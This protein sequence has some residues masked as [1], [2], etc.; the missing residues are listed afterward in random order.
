[1][2]IRPMTP[3][4]LPGVLAVQQRC[5]APALHEPLAAFASKLDGA[6]ETCWV[7]VSEEDSVVAYLVSLPVD[8]HSLPALHATQWRAPEQGQWLYLHDLA[9]SPIAQGQSL[10]PRLVAQAR[11]RAH[12][13]GLG[14]M[15]LVAVQGSEGFW[16]R[17]GFASQALPEGTMTGKLE[18]FGPRAQFMGCAL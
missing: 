13:L 14:Q 3:T 1:M 11:Q 18:S 15:V 10:A 7:A 5:Y 8:A 17:Q 2:L 16:Q 4:D 6:P 9:V 12:A